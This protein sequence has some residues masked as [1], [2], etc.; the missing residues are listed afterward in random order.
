MRRVRAGDGSGAL[1]PCLRSSATLIR[2]ILLTADRQALCPVITEEREPR[3]PS[4][5]RRSAEASGR[6]VRH[7]A[8]IRRD[9]VGVERRESPERRHEA[10]TAV[11]ERLRHVI[12]LPPFPP[13][14]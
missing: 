1:G 12:G 8:A 6:A 3:W 7:V 14:G 2:L 9:V 11:R 10:P 13:H 4:C 5:R